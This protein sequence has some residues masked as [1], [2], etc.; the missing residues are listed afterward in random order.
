VEEFLELGLTMFNRILKNNP[1]HEPAGPKGGQF[2]SGDSK[3]AGGSLSNP[4]MGKFAKTAATLFAAVMLAVNEKT[5][6]SRSAPDVIKQPVTTKEAMYKKASEALPLYEK[7]MGDVATIL[8]ATVSHDL[9]KSLDDVD[10]GIKGPMVVIAPL[11]TEES[12]MRKVMGENN[13][14]FDSVG[15]LVRGMVMVDTIAELPQVI[16]ALKSSG[17]V[18]ARPV[19][20]RFEKPT[21]SGYRDIMMNITLPNGH[22]AEVQINTKAMVSAKERL[23]HPLYVQ[24]R[25]IPA[26]A[27]MAGRAITPEENVRIA[28]LQKQQNDIYIRAFQQSL[29]LVVKR[30]RY[31]IQW[32]Y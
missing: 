25:A 11:K 5:F 1:C 8:D 28:E 30:E 12:F 2:C 23:G 13:G 4:P 6:D 22:I 32:I 7:F 10:S 16:D 9:M 3:G 29:G 26:A 20:N 15:D 27:K 24:E 19:K 31:K 18:F 17:A 21:P 14:A